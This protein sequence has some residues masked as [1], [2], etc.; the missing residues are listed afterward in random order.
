M[1]LPSPYVNRVVPGPLDPERAESYA[2]ALAMH[3]GRWQTIPRIIPFAPPA[4]GTDWTV[5]V[6]P[7]TVWRLLSLKA[8]LTTSV[9]VANRI[10]R[11]TFGDGTTTY[12]SVAPSV[13][14]TAGIAVIYAGAAIG[15]GGSIAT[16]Y[17]VWPLSSPS[18][19]QV[20]STVMGTST[21]AI[22][23]TDQWS[24]ISLY[25]FETRKRTANERAQYHEALA[26]G[27]DP[28]PYPGLLIGE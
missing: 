28:D 20:G 25:V 16:L 5:Q 19:P 12:F 2:L 10:P 13:V 4:P 27:E 17:G 6:P 15:V 8:T 3:E 26:V 21:A 24:A 14:Q 7:G 1:G 11:L 23:A 18:I 9:A 22:D